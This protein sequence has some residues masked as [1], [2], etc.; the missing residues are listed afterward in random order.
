MMRYLLYNFDKKS[1]ISFITF[2]RDLAGKYR[3]KT[4]TTPGFQNLFSKHTGADMGWFFDQW[5]YGTAIPEYRFG[6]DS[7]KTDDGKYA[8]V[9]HVKQEKVP[10]NFQMLVPITVLFEDDRY[11][12]LKLWI[13][14]PEA[15]IDLPQLPFEPKKIIFNT[16]DAV[17][18]KVKYR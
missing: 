10:G 9:C 17:L 18:C 11:I 3:W 14:Q 15:D 2:L 13:D 16:Y 7:E 6:Y 4:I 12:H 1:D 5:V 8:V